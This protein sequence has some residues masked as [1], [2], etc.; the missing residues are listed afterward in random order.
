MPIRHVQAME[1]V[2]SLVGDFNL[3]T[4]ADEFGRI[5]V[6]TD[7]VKQR[8]DEI[9]LGLEATAISNKRFSANAELC[10]A[11]TIINRFGVRKNSVGGNWFVL[12]GNV[13]CRA[14]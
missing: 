6:V 2:L 8:I 7:D 12:T 13:A 10:H 3:S 9:L 14:W 4:V 5:T 11:G 1:N